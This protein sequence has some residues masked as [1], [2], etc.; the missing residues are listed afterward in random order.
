MHLS[1][2][3]I[4]I[5]RFRSFTDEAVLSF[6]DMGV[7]LYFLKGKNKSASALGSNGA[8]KSSVIDALLWCLYGKTVQG[9]KNTD[10]TPWSGKG[11]TEVEVTLKIDK[12]EHFIRRTAN[13]NKLTINGEEAGQ[14]YVSKLVAIPFEILPYTIILG[15]RQ[16]LFFDL[17]ASEK[18][19]LFSEVLELDRWEKRSQHASELVSQLEQE[20]STKESEIRFMQGEQ[21]RTSNDFTSM[22]LLSQAWEEARSKRLEISEQQ[23]ATLQANINKVM[24]E[25]DTADLQLDRALTE[26]K[27]IKPALEK[28]RIEERSST[29]LCNTANRDL[30]MLT[31]EKQKEQELIDKVD[32]NDICPT[33]G[34]PLEDK[35]HIQP[36]KKEARQQIKA[37]EASIK[38]IVEKVKKAEKAYKVIE[39]AIEAQ[40]T[41]KEQFENDAETARDILDRLLPRIANWEAELKAI[42]KQYSENAE[43]D[44]PYSEQ[45]QTL[46]RRKDQN[47]ATIEASQKVVVTKTEYC[48]RVRFWIKG[49]KDIK[50]LTIEEILQEL[51]IT[52]NS[53][54]E[55]FGLV[56]WE[57][58]YDIERETKAGTIARGLNITV[59]SPSNKQAVRWEVWS[60]G[61]GQ[62]LRIIGTAALNSVLLNHVGV[63][64]NFECYDEPTESLSKEG[65]Q[66]LVELLAQRAKDAKKSIWFID[67]HVIESSYFVQTITVTKDKSGSYIT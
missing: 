57:V 32:N 31:F 43:Q 22:K 14:E 54:L 36:A 27:A 60:G 38:E 4:R 3:T 16:P 46:R 35:K 1:F 47:K 55:E 41:A 2:K 44:N 29:E 11:K 39:T 59:L 9:L 66:D 20:I 21:E 24:S 49:F 8:G 64:T 7:G 26:L 18:L 37:L 6:D 56:G 19:K 52:T 10:I 34:Q 25:R 42:D 15:Q 30:Q 63:T 48:E 33:C 67:H 17:T 12:T 53:M 65:V 61:E 45:L 23:K 62:R 58:K 50:L 28:L 5:V 51:E 40:L 13:P